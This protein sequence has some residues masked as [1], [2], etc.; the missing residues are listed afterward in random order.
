MYDVEALEKLAYER[1]RKRGQQEVLEDVQA[2]WYTSP[3]AAEKAR[4]LRRLDGW[5]EP[6]PPPPTEKASSTLVWMKAISKR[7]AERI[8]RAK[9]QFVR[10]GDPPPL[11]TTKLPPPL[12]VP[13][14]FASVASAASAP[15][16]V[17][18][19]AEEAG[20]RRQKKPKVKQ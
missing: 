12:P 19:D 7:K 8:A 3:A 2:I 20:P 15:E 17:A 14:D 1:G 4:S 5:M 11:V 13:L 16:H 18:L 9:D 10:V 6:P